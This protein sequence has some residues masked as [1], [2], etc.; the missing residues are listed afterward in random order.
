MERAAVTLFALLLC[1][2]GPSLAEPAPAPVAAGGDLAVTRVLEAYQAA[3]PTA[4][5]L[6]V[7]QLD[8]A[9][10]LQEAKARAAR[11]KR[12]VFF[13]STTQLEDAGDLRAGHC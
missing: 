8:W 5:E 3:R 11:E 2:A 12:P 7:F 13:V 10:S 9:G 1:A 4:A 6:R